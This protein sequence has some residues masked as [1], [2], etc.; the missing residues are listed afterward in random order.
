MV[1][2]SKTAAKAFTNVIMAEPV[3]GTLREENS[4]VY[5]TLYDNGTV[6]EEVFDSEVNE[7]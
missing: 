6:N 5:M 1:K 3:Y 4:V 2:I 7:K